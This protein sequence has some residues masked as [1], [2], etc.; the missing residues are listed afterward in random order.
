MQTG[1]SFLT[2]PPKTPGWPDRRSFFSYFV[3]LLTASGLRGKI[4][5][6]CLAS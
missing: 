6:A 2:L 4:Y 5:V 1:G 3:S